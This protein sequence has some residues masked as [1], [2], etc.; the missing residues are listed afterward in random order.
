[1]AG[2]ILAVDVGGS[3]VKMLLSAGGDVRRFASGPEL[4][5]EEMVDGVVELTGD[6]SYD[7]VTVGIP[8]PVQDGHVALEPVNLG[9]GWV[10]FDF[11]GRSATDSR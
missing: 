6:W 10:G 1:M 3:R 9:P 4:R 8:A 7:R 11:Q 5:P 2:Q